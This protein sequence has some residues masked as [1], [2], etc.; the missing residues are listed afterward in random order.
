ME[1]SCRNKYRLAP[2]IQ[3][4]RR[5]NRW[6]NWANFIIHRYQASNYG[7]LPITMQYSIRMPI[8]FLHEGRTISLHRFY[9]ALHLAFQAILRQTAN[10]EMRL[11]ISNLIHNKSS[12]VMRNQSFLHERLS[13][14]PMFMQ[15][16]NTKEKLAY[17]ISHLLAKLISRRIIDINEYEIRS[18]R[19]EISYENV[20]ILMNRLIQK[21]QRIEE[22]ETTKSI[23]VAQQIPLNSGIQTLYAKMDQ[24]GQEQKDDNIPIRRQN[25]TEWIM[26][27]A[28]QQLHIN[29]DQL[30]NQVM[31]K[32]DE[33]VVAWRER[34][35]KI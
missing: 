7:L 15:D 14:F 13:E 17:R 16:I 8:F 12:I 34:M 25:Q 3:K 33:R 22:K 10:Q 5:K 19:I 32:L 1:R 21:A 35:G 9:P 18:H 23:L 31:R 20:K 24:V 30:A 2:F 27:D 28:K 29:V 6:S 26:Q 11:I 4:A